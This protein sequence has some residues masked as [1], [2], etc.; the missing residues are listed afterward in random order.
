ME[1]KKRVKINKYI[2]ILLAILASIVT[3]Y[4]V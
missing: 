3:L 1:K 2:V 4:L